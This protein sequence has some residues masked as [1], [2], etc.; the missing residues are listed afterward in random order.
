MCC[1]A[2]GGAVGEDGAG[3]GVLMIEDAVARER[4]CRS[5]KILVRNIAC[6][7][8]QKLLLLR[9]LREKVR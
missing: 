9:V 8:S 4:S 2:G 5:S 6:M 1:G 3:S 7:E